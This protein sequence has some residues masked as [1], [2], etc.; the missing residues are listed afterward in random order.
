MKQFPFQYPQVAEDFFSLPNTTVCSHRLIPEWS[1]GRSRYGVWV[2]EVK[3]DAVQQRANKYLT[4]FKSCVHPNYSRQL[5]ITVAAA[6]F[7]DELETDDPLSDDFTPQMQK[8]ILRTLAHKRIKPFDIYVHGLNSFATAPFL[9]VTDPS[10][11][12]GELRKVLVGCHSDFR[13][14]AYVPHITL[15]LY[16]KA[17]SPERIATNLREP[18]G[19]SPIRIQVSALVLASYD[20]ESLTGPLQREWTIPFLGW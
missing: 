15:G 6:G 17:V 16:S 7:L 18:L 10:G 9:E 20:S 4:G 13:T 5:H 3:E 12:L 2:L 1:Q 11:Q 14:E 8:A 19:D